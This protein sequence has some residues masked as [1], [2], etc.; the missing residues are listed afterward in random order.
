MGIH[1][2]N[3]LR[4]LRA[5]KSTRDNLRAIRDEELCAFEEMYQPM[6]EH[7]KAQGDKWAVKSLRYA[8]ETE[9]IKIPLFRQALDRT[10]VG[11]EAD[12]YVCKVC[13]LIVEND[14]PDKCPVCGS[15]RKVFKKIE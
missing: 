8:H 15:Q 2:Y 9:K 4:A 6:I 13:G 5:V 7:A 12:Y 10:E 1:A 11:R 3:H 14:V